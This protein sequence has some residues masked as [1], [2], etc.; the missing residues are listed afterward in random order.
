MKLKIFLI[1]LLNTTFLV[2]GQQG[3]L[4]VINSN[5][6]FNLPIFQ[7][8]G[9]KYFSLKQFAKFLSADVSENN[10]LEFIQADFPDYKFIATK[11]NPFI[12]LVNNQTH[13]IISYQL[14]TSTYLINDEIFIPIKYSVQALSLALSKKIIYNGSDSLTITNRPSLLAISNNQNNI[15]KIKSVYDITGIELDNRISGPLLTIKSNKK[16]KVFNSYFKDHTLSI[17]LADVT[18]EIKN[19]NFSKTSLIKDIGIRKINS[20]VEFD[21]KVGEEYTANEIYRISGS[22]DLL[23]KIYNKTSG[24]DWFEQETKN[25]K[26]IYRGSHSQLV[27]QILSDA[28]NSFKILSKLFNYTPS[29]KIIINT[30]DVNDYGFGATTTVPENYIRLEIEP[31]EPGYENIPFNDRLQWIISHELVHV[32]VNDKVSKVESI[33]RSIFSKVAPEQ[34]QPVTILFSLLTNYSRYTPKWHQEAIAVFLETWLSGGYGRILGNFD[35]MYFRTMVAENQEFPTQLK[36]DAVLSHNSFLLESLFYIYGARFALYLAANYGT[37][38]LLTWFTAKPGDFYGG[39]KSKFKAVFGLDFDDAW[40]NFIDY[41]KKFQD[42]NIRRVKSSGLTP[43]H[44]ISKKQVGW[45]TQPHWDVYNNSIIYGYHRSHHLAGIHKLNL[46]TGEYT[47]LASLPTPSMYQVASTAF[48]QKLGLFFYTTNNNQ[49]YRD[50]K[51]LDVQTEDEKTLFENARVG[52]LT[53]SSA[54]HELWGIQNSGG[55]STLV[56]SPYPYRTLFPILAFDIG[57][58]IESLSLSPTGEFL[59]IVIHRRSGEQSIII[60]NAENLKKGDPFSYKVITNIGTPDNPSWSPN[61]NSLY[62]NAYTNGVSNIYSYNF[63][64]SKIKALSNCVTGLFRPVY[65]SADSLFAFKF[66]TNGFIPVIIPNDKS[67][68]LTAIHYLGQRVLEKDKKVLNWAVHTKE[69]PSIETE[70]LPEESYN[71]LMNLKIQTFIPVITGFQK[72]K[73]LGFYVRIGDPLIHNDI[74][75]E[76]GYAPFDEMPMVPKYHFKGKYEY[77]KQYMIEFNYNATDFYDLFNKRKRGMIGTKF[78]LQNTHYWIYDNPYK[79]M[80]RTQFD[81]YTDAEYINDN[82]TRVSEPDF[83]VAQTSIDSKDLRKSIGSSDYE[84]GNQITATTMLFGENPNDP[85]FAGEL[86]LELNHYT[87]YIV[88]HNVLHIFAAGGYFKTNQKLFQARYFFGGFGNRAVENVDVKQYRKVFRFPGIPIYS[89]DAES[90]AKLMIENDFPPIRFSSLSLWDQY[91]SH[92]DIGIY[93][94]GLYTKSPIGSKWVDVGAQINFLFKHWYNLESTFSAGI[95]QA[96]YE[97]GS[98]WEWFLSF[99]LLKN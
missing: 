15:S 38:K 88:P 78:T 32:V 36:L 39:F 4:T 62:W 16:I 29:E 82:L 84:Y 91:L 99:K 53:V 41:E 1:L 54:T 22:N 23:I 43:I 44:E 71:G 7:K 97:G 26:V 56:Y 85:Q 8:D 80:Q 57:D 77:K 92:I 42:E 27:P 47:E 50:I 58:E 28:E 11:G 6:S 93:S 48:D 76:F 61:E 95:A 74:T 2:F 37:D 9:I 96:W 5:E 40:Q 3:K 81:I 65:I 55:I 67:V 25:F 45:V 90:F 86:H 35:E 19:F 63:Q 13:E 51:V 31:L 12:K 17:I 73:V 52:N 64:T 87:T 18:A 34:N 49:L 21:I 14:P 46:S 20:D 33:S 83:F 66:S 59:A 94:Q 79:L 75:L 30:Y 98:N 69:D 68:N 89:L 72:Q 24:L 60:V 70:D 10:K